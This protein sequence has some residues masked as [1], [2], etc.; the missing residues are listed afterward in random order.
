MP[1]T[2]QKRDALRKTE[3]SFQSVA[4]SYALSY[5]LDYFNTGL[6]IAYRANKNAVYK[7]QE[8]FFAVILINNSSHQYVN[9]H[10]T[11]HYLSNYFRVLVCTQC[12]ESA[13]LP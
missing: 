12:T 10:E 1:D 6:K 4:N 7:Q 11:N 8:I 5:V 9:N 13:T 2:G 3:Y